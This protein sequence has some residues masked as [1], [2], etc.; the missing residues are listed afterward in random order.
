MRSRA[1]FSAYLAQAADN[2][3]GLELTTLGYQQ[4]GPG[5]SYPP[6]GHPPTHDFCWEKGRRLDEHHLVYMPSGSGCCETRA[7]TL[8]LEAG[9]ILLIR[10]SDW[11][12]YRPDARTGWEVYWV[13]FRGPYADEYLAPILFPDA[14][15]R[16]LTALSQGELIDSF[17]ALL[18]MFQAT[19]GGHPMVAAGLLL[20]LTGH[21]IDQHAT[22]PDQFVH[23]IVPPT[24]AMIRK[25]LFHEIDFRTWSASLNLSYSRFRTIFR[26]ATGVAPHHF[27]LDERIACAKRLLR[28]PELDLKAIAFRTG[29]D[30]PAYFSRMFKQRVGSSPSSWRAH[31]PRGR[32]AAHDGVT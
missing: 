6:P 20:Q 18:T 4:I 25:N 30:T 9:H 15:S 31:Y 14:T 12:R 2:G 27:V 22:M 32:A 26:E 17:D 28:N 10:Q 29:F 23:P 24:I 3:G 11:H 7:G 1:D 16:T 5:S 21:V 13:G 8:P 19:R